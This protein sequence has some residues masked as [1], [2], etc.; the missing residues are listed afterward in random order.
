M[1]NV[2]IT[3]RS[4][5]R[6]VGEKMKTGGISMLSEG[7]KEKGKV[8]DVGSVVALT[9][10]AEIVL[11]LKEK[12]KAKEVPPKVL[13]KE[14]KEDMFPKAKAKEKEKEKEKGKE[15]GA[16]EITLKVLVKEKAVASTTFPVEP[17][18]SPVGLSSRDTVTGVGNGGTANGTAPL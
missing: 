4:S 8:R 12:E 9:T 15:K 5:P 6:T 16:R 1:S 14:V 3:W 10:Y 11:T 17:T 7:E 13:A 18:T 2:R